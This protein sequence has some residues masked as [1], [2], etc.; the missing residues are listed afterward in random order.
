MLE[1]LFLNKAFWCFQEVEKECD[2]N[3]SIKMDSLSE[4]FEGV[5][6]TWE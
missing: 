5:C 1:S 6:Q 3:E 4:D 2:G